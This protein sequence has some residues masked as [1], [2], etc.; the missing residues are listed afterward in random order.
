[1]IYVW[2]LKTNNPM[3]LTKDQEHSIPV[4]GSLHPS[5][6]PPHEIAKAWCDFWN[7]FS[8]QYVPISEDGMTP[9]LFS[10]I[11]SGF[12]TDWKGGGPGV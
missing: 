9:C 6:L 7:Q 10:R 12:L 11:D 2:S 1:M 4:Y 5:T 3:P 8:V